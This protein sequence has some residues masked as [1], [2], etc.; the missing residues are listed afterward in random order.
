MTSKR[1]N[2]TDLDELL[3]RALADDLPPDAAAEMR[4]GLARF[5]KWTARREGG[6]ASRAPLFRKTAW[7]ALSLLFLI[8]GSLLQGRG[9]R[10][11]LS[12]GI[13]LIKTRLAVSGELAAAE[14]MSCSVRVR[15][16][17]GASFDYEI[18]WHAGSPPGVLVKR[19][20]GSRP[21]EPP[22][23]SA[24]LAALLAS[25]STPSAV[26]DR[27]SGAWRSLGTS[28][29]SGCDVGTY[30]IL[31]GDGQPALEFSI[32]MCTYLPVRIAGA[33]DAG[34]ST[35]GTADISWEAIFRF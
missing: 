26:G 23:T 7:A 16:A 3:K 27:L 29:D 5:Y 21:A 9:S 30:A 8:S 25:V 24:G 13:S 35:G 4:E 6:A 2:G 15:R 20:E 1:P 34:P 22:E 14:S 28:R 17:D 33:R 31:A 12:D 32:D 18:T 10:N 11:P 19:L